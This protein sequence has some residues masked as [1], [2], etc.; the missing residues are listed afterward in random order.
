MKEIQQRWKNKMLLGLDCITY[1]DGTVIIM[2]PYQVTDGK[3]RQAYNSAM[4]DTTVQSILKYYHEDIWIPIEFYPRETVHYKGDIIRCGEGAMGNE[5]FVS[6]EDASGNLKW[7][8][9]CTLFNPFNEMSM[10]TPDLMQL[11]STNGYSMIMDLS[12]PWK[13]TAITNSWWK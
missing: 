9:F 12:Q 7:S 2:N 5:G 6:C 4:C 3:N 13:I 1:A 10:E 11:S 8:F